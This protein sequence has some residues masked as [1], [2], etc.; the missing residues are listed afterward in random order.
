MNG[1]DGD[2][3]F[4][5]PSDRTLHVDDGRADRIGVSALATQAAALW[6]QGRHKD[7]ETLATYILSSA[8]REHSALHL[9]GLI[10]RQNGEMARAIDFFRQAIAIDDQIA[11]YH[12]N[13]GNAYFESD[14]LGEAAGC[15]RQVL[16][17]EPG[18]AQAR[19]GLGLALMAQ[20]VYDAAVDE[21]EQA[22][23]AR[24]DHANAHL[25]LGIALTELG[26]LD[27]AVAHCRRAVALDPGYAGN[28]LGLGAALKANGD[29]L[30]ARDHFANAIELDPKL[31]KGHYQ[32]GIT[33]N[34]L[35]RDEEAAKVLSRAVELFSDLA[36]ARVELQRLVGHSRQGLA[37]AA[38][39]S[40][41]LA[42]PSEATGEM[43]WPPQDC[44]VAADRLH[45]YIELFSDRQQHPRMG[46]YPGLSAR[47]WH[48]R[49]LLPRLLLV[50]G[51]LAPSAAGRRDARRA[52]RG[53]GRRL[54]RPGAP[55]RSGSRSTAAR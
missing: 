23:K 49:P 15:F 26:R 54:G 42:N 3:A 35:G 45:R 37:A 8:P 4:S 9:L 2:P 36:E 50:N 12:G 46:F 30:A 32:L 25:N 11:V 20:K 27:K 43:R 44:S 55:H 47:P 40:A 16:A 5:R 13:L 34:A 48:A 41:G 14:R 24:P 29:L 28:H 7:A 31:A 1:N 19:F 51:A 17:L 22:I 39:T 10:A 52:L 33:L 53:S 6:Q 21:L 38:T 18:A